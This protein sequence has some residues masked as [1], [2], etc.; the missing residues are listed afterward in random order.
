MYEKV[1]IDPARYVVL[2]VETNGLRSKKDDLI[3]ARPLSQEEFDELVKDVVQKSERV[4][5]PVTV[6]SKG[7]FVRSE[8]QKKRR[9]A[10]YSEKIK[11]L[12]EGKL[13]V[14]NYDSPRRDVD[15][16]C[17]VCGYEWRRR[18]DHLTKKCICPN[19]NFQG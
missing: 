4:Y 1:S 13:V 17:I 16:R 14:S 9:E 18:A 8:Y 5:S 2:D 19:C 12:S 6:S 10:E 11:R 7:N 15:I 3:D